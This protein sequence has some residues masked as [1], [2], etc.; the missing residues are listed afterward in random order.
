MS[1]AALMESLKF[2][3]E[4]LSYNRRGEFAPRQLAEEKSNEQGCRRSSGIFV[5]V[6]AAV[7]A[8]GIIT[9]SELVQGLSVPIGIFGI[10]AAGAFLLSFSKSTLK[11]ANV[12]GAAKLTMDRAESS[13]PS[14]VMIVNGTYFRIPF[15]AYN[16]IEEGAT[17]AVY[18]IPMQR[19]QILSMEKME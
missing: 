11:V 1:T 18:Y 6:A 10:L 13:A 16:A 9:R 17:Y 19:N 15:A 12:R 8:L 3:D 2:T 14:H 5:L 4:D 7:V